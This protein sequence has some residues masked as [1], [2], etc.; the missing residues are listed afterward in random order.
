MAPRRPPPIFS[1]RQ[2]QE[3]GHNLLD[4]FKDE[5]RAAYTDSG[6]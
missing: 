4:D 2:G 1:V 6:R 5:E 3:G